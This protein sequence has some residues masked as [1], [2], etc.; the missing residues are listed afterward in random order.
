MILALT[1]GRG[2]L[3]TYSSANLIEVF[4]IKAGYN[5]IFFSLSINTFDM[6]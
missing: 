2:P 3:V 1:V 6:L 5:I 4:V